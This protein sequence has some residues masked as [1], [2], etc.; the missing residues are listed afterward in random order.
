M[1]GC[2]WDNAPAE[3]KEVFPYPIDIHS[4]YLSFKQGKG[5]FF[6]C[7]IRHF[8]TLFVLMYS[9]LSGLALIMTKGN[10]YANPKVVKKST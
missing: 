4:S 1:R 8:I 9:V 7:E 10:C 2:A 5:K 3:N 6:T